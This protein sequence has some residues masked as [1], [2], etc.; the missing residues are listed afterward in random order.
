LT[1]LKST[2]FIILEADRGALRINNSIQATR[3]EGG[4]VGN[5][6]VDISRRAEGRRSSFAPDCILFRR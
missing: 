6:I 2:E 5:I 4:C 1:G 3:T